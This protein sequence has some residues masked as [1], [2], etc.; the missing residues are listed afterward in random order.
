MITVG[1]NYKIVPGKDEEFTK[2][3]TKV[4]GIMEGMDGH[5]ETHLYRDVFAEHDYLIVSEWTDEGAFEGFIHSDQFK[6]VANW[7]KENVLRDRPTHEVYGGQQAVAAVA[8]M[9]SESDD[10]D[11]ASAAGEG[12]C[13][14]GHG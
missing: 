13:P 5:T 3:F 11:N 7:G 2:V 8:A 12:K 14:F 1:M 4:I 10:S 6:N 9:R